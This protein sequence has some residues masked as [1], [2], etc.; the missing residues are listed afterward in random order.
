MTY[1]SKVHSPQQRKHSPLCNSQ[2]PFTEGPFGHDKGDDDRV[3]DR[4]QRVDPRYVDA[5]IGFRELGRLTAKSPGSLMR[6]LGPDGNPRAR[7]L[8]AII[9]CLQQREDLRLEVRAVR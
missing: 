5:T 1:A 6:M 7:D 4:V 9:G 8:F 2:A 3:M